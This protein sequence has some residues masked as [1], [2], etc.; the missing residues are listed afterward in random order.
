MATGDFDGDGRME[1]AASNTSLGGDVWLSVFRYDNDGQNSPRLTSTVSKDLYVTNSFD[2][3]QSLP[4]ADIAAGRLQRLGHDQV[5]I[6]VVAQITVHL[7]HGVR[8]Q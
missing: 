1:I 3:H 4:Y 5:M 7:G 2:N 6:G 8:L